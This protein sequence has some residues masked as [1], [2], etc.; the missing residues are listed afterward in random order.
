MKLDIIKLYKKL[1]NYIYKNIYIFLL[2]LLLIIIIILKN[3]KKE[4]FIDSKDVKQS[5]INTINT[6]EKKF[7]NIFSNVK[8]NSVNINK[9]II[10]KN[11]NSTGGNFSGDTRFGKGKILI[12]G[13]GTIYGP[14]LNTRG[15]ENGLNVWGGNI[16]VTNKHKIC[17]GE[18]CINEDQLKVLTGENSF[19]LKD[20]KGTKLQRQDKGKLSLSWNNGRLEKWK[21]EAPRA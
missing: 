5:I 20:N 17:I 21:I 2:L 9:N 19:S 14:I 11:I 12:G 18:T 4:M 1:Y 16:K 6:V 3:K 13:N 8:E 7:N 15:V 10:T